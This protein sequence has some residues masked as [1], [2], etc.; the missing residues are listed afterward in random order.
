M[1]YASGTTGQW[2]TLTVAPPW[3]RGCVHISS[4]YGYASPHGGATVRVSH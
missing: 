2:E 4:I 1:L 3:V